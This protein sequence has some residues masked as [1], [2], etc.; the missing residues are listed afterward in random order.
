MLRVT[1]S[2][3]ALLNIISMPARK[4]TAQSQ[5]DLSAPVLSPPSTRGRAKNKGNASTQERA[6][7]DILLAAHDGSPPPSPTKKGKGKA[8]SSSDTARNSKAIQMLQKNADRSVDRIQSVETG[9]KTVNASVQGL[10]RKF[11]KKLDAM[12]TLLQNSL[13][14]S[15]G[16]G[17]RHQARASSD[18]DSPPRSSRFTD[19]R[20]SRRPP[21]VQ[22]IPPPAQLRAQENSDG[23]LDRM[24]SREEFRMNSA[25]GKNQLC[26]EG[27]IVKPYMY[28]EREGI[29]TLR[30]KLDIRESITPLEYLSA[31]LRLLHDSSAYRPCDRDHILRHTMAVSI[32]ALT[33]SWPG[34]R[35][36]SQTIW[37][38]VEKGWCKWDDAGFIHDE[39]V[40]IS[41]TGAAPSSAS[42]SS[43][44]SGR[45]AG[46]R[47]PSFPCKDF[48]SPSGC[49]HQASHEDNGIRYSHSCAYC[50]SM[51][52]RSNH[53]V[54]KCRAKNDAYYHHHHG[55]NGRHGNDGSSWYNNS[56]R[57]QG[58][59][60]N[61]NSQYRP[62]HA[63]SGSASK[64]D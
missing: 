51:G 37:D 45:A 41:Y 7:A 53:S 1:V 47:L 21:H 27:Q 30:Q 22:G 18:E 6:P 60:G 64:N 10:D 59:R 39:R 31:S 40:R 48:N 28:I 14:Q 29:Q 55:S 9:L 13:S 50:D 4:K 52:R 35:R 57:H 34:V 20:Q 8:A 42:S 38:S 32:D 12:M 62:S 5:D 46:E 3:G 15:S 24:F 2:T 49:K 25:N 16:T 19:H 17:D 58:N 44:V 61:G 56:N 63:S 33:R 36:W 54:Q 43:A 23:E 26:S 11:D